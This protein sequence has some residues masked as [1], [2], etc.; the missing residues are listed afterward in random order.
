MRIKSK[1][2]ASALLL[3]PATV[4]LVLNNKPGVNEATRKRVFDYLEEMERTNQEKIKIQNAENKGTILFLTY[5]K[6][7]LILKQIGNQLGSRLFD[8]MQAQCA[9]SGYRFSYEVYHEKTG[10]LEELL[11]SIKCRNIKGI[12]FMAAEM[13]QSDIYPFLKLNIPIVIGDN[14]FYE[15]GVDSYLVDNREG[16]RRGVDYL[17]DK[18]HSHIVY[19]AQSVDIFNFS[20]RRKAFI[21]EMEI[22]QCGDG[23]NRMLRL[24]DTVQAVYEA[25]N[26]YLDRGLIK[27]TAFVLESSVITLG[28]T[29]ALLERN[30]KIPREISLIGFDSLPMQSI[31]GLNLTLIKGTHTKRHLAGMKHLIRRLTEL[32]DETIRVYYRT[33]LIEGDSV[34]DK[35]KYIY[36]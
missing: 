15:L 1:D 18:G 21:E 7:G 10:K 4:S 20:E 35:K 8:D 28:A 19:L 9:L 6:H 29:K 33:R 31:P 23:T 34:F 22:R 16:I 12:Y 30:I 11:T 36:H 3:S 2:I 27:T 13:I 32:E 14:L 24:G 17:V 25:M 26:Q 5:I